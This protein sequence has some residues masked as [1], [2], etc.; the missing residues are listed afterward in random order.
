LSIKP[1]PHQQQCRSNNVEATFDFV[2]ATFDFVALDILRYC[3]CGP[4]FTSHFPGCN[5]LPI[6]LAASSGKRN[7]TVWRPSVRLSRRRIFV[8]THHGAARDAAS[9]HFRS[10]ITRTDILVT[11]DDSQLLLNMQLVPRQLPIITDQLS[12]PGIATGPVCESVRACTCVWCQVAPRIT[13]LTYE[14]GL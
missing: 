10:S 14:L 1:G 12:G 6:T 7:V 8:V 11:S 2:E 5:A 4:G 3:W 9:V 13:K